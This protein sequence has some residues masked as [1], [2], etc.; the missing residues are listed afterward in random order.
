[1]GIQ[2]LFLPQIPENIV[3]HDQTASDFSCALDATIL[4]ILLADDPVERLGMNL[5]ERPARLTLN[6]PNV[7]APSCLAQKL[8]GDGAAFSLDEQIELAPQEI[9][10]IDGDRI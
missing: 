2:E 4:R 10:G 3:E 5:I 1:M 8:R 9:P 6:L 7:A